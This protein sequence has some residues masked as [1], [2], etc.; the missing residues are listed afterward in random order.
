MIDRVRSRSL[1]GSLALA[2]LLAAGPA[3]AS[4]TSDL[5]GAWWFHAIASGP[6]QPWWERAFGSIAADGALTGSAVTS[7]GDSSA[8]AGDFVV[9]PSGVVS[10]A[11]IASFRGALDVGS[12][13]MVATDTWSGFAAGTTELR[14]GVKALRPASTP[15]LSGVWEIHSLASGPGAPWWQRGRIAIDAAGAFTG[16]FSEQGGGTDP[17]SGTFGLSN[18]GVLSLSVAPL[19]HGAI[20]AGRTVMALSN[21]W[22]G[23]AAGTAELNVGVRVGTGYA[24]SDLAGTWEI[25]RLASGP[26]APWWGR[27]SVTVAPTGAF[28]GTMTESTIGAY[29]VSGTFAISPT[30][31]VT[32]AGEPAASGA[33]DA[34][35][36]VLVMTDTWSTGSPGTSELVVGVRTSGATADAPTPTGRT[37]L[38][39]PMRPNPVRGGTP[40]VAFTLARAGDVRLEWLDASGRSFQSLDLSGLAA[41]R[42]ERVLQ[43]ATAAPPGLY[44]IRL[45]QAGEVR[46]ARFALVDPVR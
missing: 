27:G 11:Q 23:F 20:D 15:D 45:T 46:T 35:R 39:E 2:A 25:H 4:D 22:T 36:S 29:P 6:G 3:G 13:V 43:P 16:S 1:V 5:A 42:H 14:V 37:L 8:I 21:T 41:G 9:S 24:T 31:G 17:V 10:I 34:G 44:W 7:D 26:G 40:R 19:A 32:R 12:T 30:G 33:L 38:L 28:T 18:D